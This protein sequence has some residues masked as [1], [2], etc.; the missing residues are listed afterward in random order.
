MATIA[1]PI[2]RSRVRGVLAVAAWTVAF[3]VLADAAMN[4]AFPPPP[5]SVRPEKVRLHAVRAY[6]NY[7]RSIEGK[8]ALM[9]R[10]TD[11][12]SAP[13]VPV[14][15]VEGVAN[16]PT[17]TLAPGGVPR[18]RVASFG[19]S[20][21]RDISLAAHA[22]DPTVQVAFY[23]GP[24]AP[25]NHAFALYRAV[26][27]LGPAAPPADVAVWGILA[28][29]VKGMVTLTGDTWMFDAPAPFCYPRYTLDAAGQLQ[30]RWPSIRTEADLRAAV[31]DPARMATFRADL[32]AGDRFYS[33]FAFRHNLLDASALGRMI[34]RAYASHHFSA[35]AATI[36]GKDGFNPDDRDIGPTL[37]A[38]CREFAATVR[39]DG[40]RPLVLL[41]QDQGSDADLYK[42]LGPSLAADGVPYLST[43]ELVPARDHSNF[44]ADGHF[45]AAA[46]DRVARAM[47]DRLN[48]G[49]MPTK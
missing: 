33:P 3:L 17:M 48:G 24:E 44:V 32:S 39:A 10:P 13:L 43:H 16:H 7:G 18:V 26:R 41:I 15:W 25:P 22:L 2:K 28:S 4:R 38:M 12:A 49:P 9:V 20:F 21:S 14:G 34:R 47:L 19:M 6:L 35:V 37:K 27:A 5:P 8:L 31:A 40:R 30:E 45:T 1:N 42:L 11:A 36:A 29:A 46:Y 23:G